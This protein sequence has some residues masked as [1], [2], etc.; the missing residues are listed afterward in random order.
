MSIDTAFTNYPSLTTDRLHLRQIQLADAEALFAIRSDPAVREPYGQEPAQSI[1]EAREFIQSTHNFYERRRAI[2]WAVTL[3]GEDTVIGSCT[4]WNFNPDFSCAETGYE[5]NR[6]YW[7]LGLIAEA[8]PAVLTFG[9]HEIGL[10]RIEAIV[11]AENIPSRNV[12]LR[13]GFTF[14]GTLRQR[15]FFR[16]HYVDEQYFSML[17]DEWHASR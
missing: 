14:E 17:K 7:R 4:L 6:A 12:L 8:L 11:S 5:L 16:D 15:Y 10:H 2:Y 1:E 3:K 9:F 13:L